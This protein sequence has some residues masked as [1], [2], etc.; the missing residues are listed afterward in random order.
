MNPTVYL[1]DEHDG[2]AD[3]DA[4]ELQQAGHLLHPLP[5][6]HLRHGEETATMSCQNTSVTMY[7]SATSATSDYVKTYIHVMSVMLCRNITS[8]MTT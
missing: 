4:E 6:Q 2:E 8:N 7:T 3:A 1:D 5:V